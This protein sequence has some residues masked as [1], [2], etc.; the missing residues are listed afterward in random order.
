MAARTKPA[1]AAQLVITDDEIAEL[2]LPWRVELGSRGTVTLKSSASF[3]LDDYYTIA[4]KA[5]E[6]PRQI[7]DL[8][9][10]DDGSAKLLRTIGHVVLK[11]ILTGWF[12]HVGVATGESVSSET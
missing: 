3:C 2:E 12:A 4:D 1:P 7:L 10:Y 9:A 11:R 5:D 8:I 6:D